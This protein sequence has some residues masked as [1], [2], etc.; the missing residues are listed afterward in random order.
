MPKINPCPW[1]GNSHS[2]E[3]AIAK[4]ETKICG[5]YSVWLS[6]SCSQCAAQGPESEDHEKAIQLWNN[7]PTSDVAFTAL[8]KLSNA[9]IRS[10]QDPTTGLCK[11]CGA[12]DDGAHAVDCP[13]AVAAKFVAEWHIK[14]GSPQIP[15]PEKPWDIIKHSCTCSCGGETTLINVFTAGDDAEKHQVSCTCCGMKG[16]SSYKRSAAIN[17]WNMIVESLMGHKKVAEIIHEKAEMIKAA[18]EGENV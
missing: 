15:T 7:G 14:N 9:V 5:E 16:P 6:V 13:A 3:F 2:E 1:C 18:R 10:T 17:E 4:R 8:V 11:I 12:G